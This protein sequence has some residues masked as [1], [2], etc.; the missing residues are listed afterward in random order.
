MSNAT[1]NTEFKVVNGTPDGD[2][3]EQFHIYQ[4]IDGQWK[5]IDY[6]LTQSGA[7]AL[8]LEHSLCYRDSTIYWQV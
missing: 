1:R 7:H 2:P 4:K 3:V 5:F 8:A 6:H